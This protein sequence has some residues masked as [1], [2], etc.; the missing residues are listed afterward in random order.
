MDIGYIYYSEYRNVDT[1]GIQIIHTC[2]QL[3]EICNSVTLFTYGDI[4]GFAE[5]HELEINFKIKKLPMKTGNVYI[6]RF[7]YYSYSLSYISK[8]DVIFTRCIWFLELLSK[9]PYDLN[10]PILYEAHRSYSVMGDHSPAD[11]RRRCKQA[12]ATIAISNRLSED[13]EQI[14]ISVTEVVPDAAPEAYN[15]TK[16]EEAIKQEYNIPTD[17][18]IFTYTG[19]LNKYKNDIKMMIDGFNQVCKNNEDVYLIIVGN[20]GDYRK[21]DEL[22]RADKYIYDNNFE[23]IGLTG[24][25]PHKQAY[26]IQY[27]SDIGILPL[28]DTNTLSQKYTSPLKLYEYLVN[29]LEVVASDVPS[30]YSDFSG[31]RYTHFYN[32]GDVEDYIK[33]CN[34]ALKLENPPPRQQKFSYENRAKKIRDILKKL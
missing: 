11:E 4:R 31:S 29:G 32:P 5:M 34:Q 23:K 16:S 26:E 8:F 30:V 13:L 27:I 28:T 3:E 24:R 21:Y 1:H 19:N 14:G 25:I 12:D 33:A 6:D 17:Y 15:I 2:N 9:V 18:T 22:F 20:Y 7:S 10:T